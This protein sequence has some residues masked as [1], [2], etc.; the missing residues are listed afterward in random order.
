MGS[1]A[2]MRWSAGP[3]SAGSWW[4]PERTAGC[5]RKFPP[6][7]LFSPLPPRWTGIRHTHTH[8]EKI[9]RTNAIRTGQSAW[10][11]CCSYPRQQV[12]ADLTDHRRLA[13]L[14]DRRHLFRHRN[15]RKKS[16]KT[17]TLF[18]IIRTISLCVFLHRVS[19]CFIFSSLL[20]ST[21]TINRLLS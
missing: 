17:W 16:V 1:P 7:V 8:T 3:S 12:I 10:C 4:A 6:P 9:Q 14:P 13:P 15:C 18:F 11:G 5:Y 2:R 19:T 20:K 21:T